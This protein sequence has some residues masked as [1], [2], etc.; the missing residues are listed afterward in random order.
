MYVYINVSPSASVEQSTLHDA[1]VILKVYF[2]Q[3]LDI[4]FEYTMTGSGKSLF[5]KKKM[6][7]Q[8]FLFF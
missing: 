3:E 7:K 6:L 1:G 4:I 2:P 5:F 8:S